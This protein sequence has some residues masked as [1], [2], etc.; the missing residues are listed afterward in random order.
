MR[1]SAFALGA[2]ARRERR[3]HVSYVIGSGVVHHCSGLPTL[4]TKTAGT[5]FAR[6]HTFANLATP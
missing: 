6:A 4:L 1:V 3:D 5:E 2:Q